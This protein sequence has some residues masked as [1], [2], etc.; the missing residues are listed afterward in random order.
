MDNN[1]D[2][3]NRSINPA[4]KRKDPLIKGLKILGWAI[5]IL[6]LIFVTTCSAVVWFLNPA[7]LTPIAEKLA[8]D[9]IDGTVTIGRA[10]LTFWSSFPKLKIEVDD[11]TVVSRSLD[12][13]PN[14]I[15]CQL[16]VD[17]DSLMSIGHFNGSIDLLKIAG[18]EI[19][20]H[21]VLIDR[22]RINLL[23]VND[24]VANF[25]II[26]PSAPDDTTKSV[27]P[28][29]SINHFAITNARPFTYRS[30]SDSIDISLQ[31]Q[32][33][34]LA[35]KGTPRYQ[36]ALATNID[37]P[38]LRDIDF[39]SS[40]LNLDSSISWS[41]KDPY[42]VE[43][44]DLVFKYEKIDVVINA[45]LDFRE[46]LRLDKFDLDVNRLDIDYLRR[47][48]PG[49]M[50]KSLDTLDTDMVVNVSTRLKK[51]FVFS[52][53][54]VLP[55][56]GATIEIPD[57]HI[58]YRNADFE[59]FATSLS[60]DFRGDTINATTVD[61]GHII[62]NG[63]A[64]DID[65]RGHLSDLFSDPHFT[66][67]FA[68]SIDFNRLPAIVRQ[69]IPGTI[70][71][72]LEADN[73]FNVRLS[74]F[75]RNRFH[76][77]YAEGKLTLTDF[78]FI[79]ADSVTGIY[80]RR[81]QLE[82][83]S[84]E[85]IKG[86]GASAD[87]LLI[88]KLTVDTA[89]FFTEG[90]DTSLRDL[91]AG[92]GSANRASSADTTIINPFGGA[93]SFGSLKYFSISDSTRLTLRDTR[94]MASLRR[95]NGNG[96]I[97]ELNMQL[98]A[99]RL[100]IADKTFGATLR[101]S[102]LTFTAHLNPRPKRRRAGI[103]NTMLSADDSTATPRPRRQPRFVLTS[104]QLDSLGV[105]TIDFDVDNSLRSLLRRW[106]LEGSVTSSR[107][108]LRIPSLRL[109]N[110]FSN[111][112]LSFTSDSISLANLDYRL[113]QSDFHVNGSVANIL[114][115]LNR[116][117]P[118]ALRID[119]NVASDTINVNQIVQAA[120]STHSDIDTADILENESWEE[121]EPEE[122]G[123][124]LSADTIGPVLIPV[125]IDAAFRV[126][127]A[128]I[129]YSDMLLHNFTGD[130]MIYRG[131]LSLQNLSADTE[132]GSVKASALYSAPTADNMQLGLGMALRKFHIGKL[133][134]IV[135]GIDSILPMI[136]AFSGLVDAR[137]ATTVDIEPNMDINLP[138]LR[139][140]MRFKGDSLVVLDNATFRTLSKWLM[141][142][143]KNRNMIDSLNVELVV[144][145]NTLEIYPFIVDIDR[146]RLG[147]M[148]YNDLAFNLNYHISVLKSP[149]PFKFGINIKGDVDK[150]KI[151]F[152]GAKFKDNMV[153]ERREIADTTRINLVRQMASVFRRG[154]RAAR[155]GP[156]E[157]K[158]RATEDFMNSSEETISHADSLV[159][160][161]EGMIE[162]PD[163]I[164]PI[165][166]EKK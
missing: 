18:G 159:M 122:F 41:G 154:V 153:T 142:K 136:S 111:L 22:P 125:N 124:E 37:T 78:S 12:M 47:H 7:R 58:R 107:G 71:G 5:A 88:V 77:L 38:L 89:R 130:L 32:T 67:T 146:Y 87:S 155:L 29:I 25:N 138:S 123:D 118:G 160:I 42:R 162:A 103:T 43:L 69:S 99:G 39:E 117:R 161:R 23:Q 8:S 94:G 165:T 157:I 101:D 90:V 96:R 24:S 16:P 48:L 108:R 133:N 113:G 134:K 80:T 131:T 75:D 137:I 83:G 44:S 70:A 102:R 109:R 34:D 79:S 152:G 20:L 2:N 135:P 1:T 127:A 115:A 17:A 27:I 50:R 76:R 36:F 82:F 106:N 150:P 128:N 120:T 54:L 28:D 6:I 85:K 59:H 26:Q 52:D 11:L 139:A 144:E 92:V 55:C 46:D 91:R 31:L 72:K 104:E 14:E 56:I 114:R 64:V 33:I 66:G 30:L 86:K 84:N 95:F 129:A 143:D 81:S 126:R 51:P 158:N 166:T 112:E 62:I 57:C 119:L 63:R 93:I 53:S 163:S 73:R 49:A 65:L 147:V 105:E 19:A 151:R 148:G 13:L 3:K 74:D 35:D 9:N 61:I 116:R 10:E 164:P 21:D 60:T 110:S 68:G 156:L 4:A 121:H 140:A 145:D 100:R 132:A 98:N 141:F 45:I 149:I 15:R 40:Q 97:P